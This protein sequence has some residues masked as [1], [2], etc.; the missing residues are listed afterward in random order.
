MCPLVDALS[1][2]LFFF[3]FVFIF[4]GGAKVLR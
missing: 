1:R 2:V 3:G 4:F